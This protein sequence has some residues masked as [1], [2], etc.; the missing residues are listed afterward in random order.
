[1]T[2]ELVPVENSIFYM[3]ACREAK[4]PCE[5]HLFMEGRHGMSLANE[6]W[7]SNNIGEGSIYT[8]MQ[9]WQTMKILYAQNPSMLPKTFATAKAEKLADFVVE[10]SKATAE[11]QLPK[12]QHAD[13]SLCVT[14]IF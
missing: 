1:L 10:W 5:L 14:C 6:E 13:T 12:E 4:V 11:Y 9:Q 7:A 3:Q 2:D 8:M